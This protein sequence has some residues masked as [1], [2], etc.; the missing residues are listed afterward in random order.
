[1]LLARFRYHLIL[2]RAGEAPPLLAEECQTLAFEGAPVEA[3]W[4]DPAAAEHLLDAVPDANVPEEQARTFIGQVLERLDLLGSR[5]TEAADARGRALLD[6]H[7]RV[8]QSARDRV[9]G[10][11]VEPVPPADLLGIYVLLPVPRA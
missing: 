9:R 10:L 4:L 2:G 1:M 8:R 3:R 11:R 7:R 6:A 5:L